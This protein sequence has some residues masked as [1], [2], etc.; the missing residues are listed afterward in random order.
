[1][2]AGRRQQRPVRINKRTVDALK[3]PAKGEP[4]RLVWDERLKGFGVRVTAQGIKSYVIQYRIGGRGART[5]RFTIGRHG[6]PFTA[7]TARDRAEKLLRQARDGIDPAN[8]RHALNDMPT[9]KEVSE[10]YLAEHAELRKKPRS[11]EEDRRNLRLHIWPEL[12]SHRLSEITR[13]TALKFHAAMKER[14]TAANRC[15]ALLSHIFSMA[16]SPKWALLPEGH[17]PFRRIDKYPERKRERFLSGNELARLG[18]ALAASDGK[19]HPSALAAIRLLLLTGARLSEILT[20]EWRMVDLERKCL[21]LPDSKTGR[22]V[23]PLG[24]PALK[25]LKHLGERRLNGYVLPGEREDRHFIGIQRPWQRVRSEAKLDDV[26]LHDL[27]HSFASVA[28][29]SGDSLFLIGK[30]LGHRQ[31]ATT[32]RYSHIDLDPARA[33]ADRTARQIAT[34]MRATRGKSRKHLTSNIVPMRRS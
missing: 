23:I 8:L 28:A 24:A 10:R 30:V 1:M 2:A 27:R 26:R 17:N 19:E 3:P 25:V 20:L 11:V 16:A 13:W 31:A 14:P 33:V 7:E 32:E 29:A 4:E 9:V 21:R 5:R 18:D 12:G 22:K 34:A 6:S 15:A